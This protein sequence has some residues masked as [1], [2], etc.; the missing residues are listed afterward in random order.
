MGRLAKDRTVWS[1]LVTGSQ[2][3]HHGETDRRQDGVEELRCWVTMERFAKDRAVWS[4]LVTGSQLGHRGE[5]GRGQGCVE[6]LSYW[7]TAGAPW[8]N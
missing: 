2:L 1:G 3:G 8:R 6:W 7:V 4:G 5:T